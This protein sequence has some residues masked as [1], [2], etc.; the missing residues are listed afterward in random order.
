MVIHLNKTAPDFKNMFALEGSFVADKVFNKPEWF[1][2]E[3]YMTIVR[4]EE[5]HGR[6]QFVVE[7]EIHDEFNS[8]FCIPTKKNEEHLDKVLR[9]IPHLDQFEKA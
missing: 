9:G 2:K 3:N 8:V 6:S 5:N 1:K 7:Y 4:P